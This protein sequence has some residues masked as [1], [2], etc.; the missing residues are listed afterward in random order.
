MRSSPSQTW[1]RPWGGIL[2]L[3]GQK[4]Q[5]KV[6]LMGPWNW[7]RKITLV[8]FISFILCPQ[9]H[10]AVGTTKTNLQF[11]IPNY[12]HNL[13]EIFLFLCINQSRQV[14]SALSMRK[15]A[16]KP[17]DPRLATGT[18]NVLCFMK[19]KKEL[20][21][22]RSAF[23]CIVW[24]FYTA[25]YRNQKIDNATSYRKNTSTCNYFFW[26]YPVEPEHHRHAFRISWTKQNMF[27]NQ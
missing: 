13:T 2:C 3:R 17:I 27:H 21:F 12:C 10:L 5:R 22:V 19:H 18:R 25:H 16:W 11:T 7:D 9:N 14:D 23:H 15:T 20:C 4:L 6:S 24:P 8:C 1:V 26:G